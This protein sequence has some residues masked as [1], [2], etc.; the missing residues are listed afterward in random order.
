[1]SASK[2]F[3]AG[4]GTGGHLYPGLAVAEELRELEP[5]A[6][7]T[8]LTSSRPLDRKL[9]ERTDYVQIEQ[10]VKPLTG[11]P[12][13]MP[14]FLSSWLGSVRQARRIMS[15]QR[16]KAVLGLGGYAAGPAVVA[17]GKLGIPSRF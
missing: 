8:F 1:M 3:F 4:G 12:L 17:A 16:P 7:I 5:A 14:A 6:E 15:E 13:R 2:Y 9:L 10:G 11:N